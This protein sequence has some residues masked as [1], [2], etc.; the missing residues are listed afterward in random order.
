M[1][2]QKIIHRPSIFIFILLV[3]LVA[4]IFAQPKV[5]QNMSGTKTG[6]TPRLRASVRPHIRTFNRGYSS[7]ASWI[8]WNNWARFSR[9]WNL[10]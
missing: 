4:F 7:L 8:S 2:Y 9:R 1:V 3:L 5:L 6:F 10:S